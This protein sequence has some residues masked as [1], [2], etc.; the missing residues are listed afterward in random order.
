[1]RLEESYILYPMVGLLA[2]D[3]SL[4]IY[5]SMWKEN[6]QRWRET[7]HISMSYGMAIMVAIGV[8]GY[9]TF[10]DDTQGTY[11]LC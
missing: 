8:L 5:Q 3:V 9:A 10:T 4:I 7:V 2:H 1:M 6:I 11:I